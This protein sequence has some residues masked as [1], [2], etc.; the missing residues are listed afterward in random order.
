MDISKLEERSNKPVSISQPDLLAPEKDKTPLWY[1]NNVRFFST[2]YNKP[3]NTPYATNA[4]QINENLT[5]V[6]QMMRWYQYYEG[7]QTNLNFNHIQNSSTTA[8]IQNTWTNGQKV[9]QIVDYL[10]GNMSETLVNA[11]IGTKAYSKYAKNRHSKRIEDAMLKYDNAPIFEQMAKEFGVEFKPAFPNAVQSEKDIAFWAEFDY[12]EQGEL[13]AADI[14][15]SLYRKNYGYSLYKDLFKDCL[16]AGVCG[17]HNFVENGLIKQ[18]RI[19]AYNLIWDNSIQDDYNRKAKFGGLVEYMAPVDIVKQWGGKER[20]L[21]ET[22]IEEIKK[23]SKDGADADFISK[24]DSFQNISWY[25][26]RPGDKSRINNIAVVTMYFVCLRD[27]RY[28][29]TEDNYQNKLI[30]KL[31]DDKPK[32]KNKE[33][34]YRVLDVYKATVIGN[35][36]LVDWGLANNVVRDHE[37]PSNP[38]LPVRIYVPNMIMDGYRSLVSRIHELQD[39]IDQCRFKIREVVGRDLGKCYMLRGDKL[40]M[41]SVREIFTDLKSIGVTVV[42]P[43]GEAEDPS[44]NGSIIEPIDL[45]LDPN[46]SKYVELATYYE[47][48]MEEIASVPKIA[49]GQQSNVG[50]GVQ[51]GTIQQSS[52][53]NMSFYMGFIKYVEETLQYATNC[54]KNVYCIE[55]N[56]DAEMVIGERGLEYIRQTEEFTFDNFLIFLR[57]ENIIDEQMRREMGEIAFNLSQNGLID[58]LD[59]IKIKTSTNTTELTNYFEYSINKKKRE[60]Q[61][62]QQQQAAQAQE[63]QGQALAA[64]QEEVAMK[65]EG[66]NA[67]AANKNQLDALIA[68]SKIA[69]QPEME[70]AN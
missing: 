22:E 2:F 43:S 27:T 55:N 49:L 65:E 6:D 36:W 63:M 33:G 34:D 48:L 28:K 45:T 20:G 61:Q 51:E 58:M 56:T 29:E 52:K 69:P 13:Y 19:P 37:N 23:L 38:L 3:F 8:T 44:N 53:A 39:E 41:V 47:T 17:E 25:G 15:N 18:K 21:D 11:K 1:A 60:A 64:K 59:F 46:V 42:T 62:A 14:A 7:R 70:F 57:I 31:N 54:Q 24:Y 67:R 4:A 5:P 16:I 50:L 35:K 32:N 26:R 68:A 9:K 10:E 12:K 40:G 66:Q 30:K